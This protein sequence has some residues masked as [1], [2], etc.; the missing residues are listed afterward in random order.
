MI[1]VIVGVILMLLKYFEIGPVA[2][3]SWWWVIAPLGLAVLWFEVFE[4][5]FGF[6]QRKKEHALHDKIREERVAKAFA[7]DT[8]KRA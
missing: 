4:R 6:D 3:L 7:K 5:V 2:T 8:K 1:F